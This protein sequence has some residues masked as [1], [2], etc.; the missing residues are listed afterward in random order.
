MA[1][2]VRLKVLIALTGITAFVGS[3]AAEML[4]V[5]PM[6]SVA[7]VTNVIYGTS[8]DGNNVYKNRYLD[9]YIPTGEGVPDIKPAIVMMHG[10]GFTEGDKLLDTTPIAAKG[11]AIEFAKRGYLAVSINYRLLDELPAPPGIPLTPVPA[12]FPDWLPAW[13]ISQGVS[14]QQYFDEIAAAVADQA[15]AVNWLQTNAATYGIDPDRIAI[16]GS[17]AG[18]VSSLLLGSGAVDGAPANVGAVFSIAGGL[19]GMEPAVDSNDPAVFALH[20]TA[21]ATIPYSEIGYL[22][23]AINAA[24]LPL[25]MR[26]VEGGTH[27]SVQFALIDNPHFYEFMINQLDSNDDYDLDDLS[28]WNEYIAGSDPSNSA[29]TSFHITLETP[30]FTLTFPTITNR[31]YA[32]ESGAP[33]LP[34]NMWSS[35]TNNLL[36]TGADITLPLSPQPPASF[37][38]VNIRLP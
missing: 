10:G 32:V 16:G 20:G 22:E 27:T 5:D 4:Y 7:V 35:V 12:R 36:G 8:P 34:S 31:V 13:L 37:F 38:R 29:S 19:I 9:I 23:T 18:A 11:Y 2:R 25:G 30:P 6:F 28:N 15:M 14:E 26:I 21:D 3:A 33:S 24:G 17:S 1:L